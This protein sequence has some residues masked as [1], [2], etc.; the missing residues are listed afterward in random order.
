MKKK[1][2]NFI[3]KICSLLLLGIISV[4][5]LGSWTYNPST[6]TITS[7]NLINAP[8]RTGRYWVSNQT[9][10]SYAINNLSNGNYTISCDLTPLS[11]DSGFNLD[12]CFF[13][14]YITGGQY[15]NVGIESVIGGYTNINE[16]KNGSLSF[17]KENYNNY[18]F[19]LWG[20]GNHNGGNHGESKIS[21]IMLNVGSSALPYE[22]YGTY[23]N[24]TAYDDMETSRDSWRSRYENLQTMYSNLQANYRS[25]ESDYNNAVA[26][27]GDLEDTIDGLEQ[28]IIDLQTD[29]NSLES[30]YN[31]LSSRYS[32]LVDEFDTLLEEKQELQQEYNTLQTQYNTLHEQYTLLENQINGFYNTYKLLFNNSK[33]YAINSLDSLYGRDVAYQYANRNNINYEQTF[34]IENNN[35]SFLD[36]PDFYNYMSAD[37]YDNNINEV[38]YV[39]YVLETYS[40]FSIFL[41]D[42]GENLTANL[43]VNEICVLYQNGFIVTGNAQQFNNTSRYTYNINAIEN[44]PIIAFRVSYNINPNNLAVGCIVNLESSALLNNAY[45][46]LG[47]SSLNQ[48]IADKNVL[49]ESLSANL[50][51]LRIQYNTIREQYDLI[52][53]KPL[54]LNMR[55]LIWYIAET[56]FTSFKTI[57]NVDFLGLNLASFVTGLLSVWIVIF[58]IKKIFK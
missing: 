53:N 16:T 25:L 48:E 30:N 52:S 11:L 24:K 9:D 51:D 49:I 55:N 14:L 47:V 50:S 34:T 1:K 3:I 13:I 32:T 57:W 28:Q 15:G 10:I 29:Y 2:R 8:D 40:D 35:I 31:D 23:V 36:L 12:E 42:L 39:L 46:Q 41:D 22:P 7:D 45:Y 58:I 38:Y 18:E 26:Q 43:W 19:D 54:D 4:T 33:C 44:N 21:N 20:I 17:V 37:Y 56:P 27:I 5:L 6:D